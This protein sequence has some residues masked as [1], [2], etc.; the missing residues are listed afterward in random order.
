MDI[1]G[2]VAIVFGGASGLGAATAQRLGE[3]GARVAVADRDLARATEVAQ[4]I[5][6]LPIGVD[7]SDERSAEEAIEAVGG[8]GAL[9]ICVN[10]AGVGTPGKLVRKGAPAP[11][12]SFGDV[13]AVNLL[14]TI[15]VLR[16]AASAMQANELDAG[17]ERGVC[18][19]TASIAAFDGQIGQIAYAASKAGVAGVTLPAAR[20]LAGSAI[21]VVT[22]APGIFD[23]P[24][25]AGL[26]AA[27]RQS[28]EGTV[29]F[30]SRL[31]SPSEYA[32]LVAHIVANQMLNGEVIRLD[33]ALRMAAQ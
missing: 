13:L 29:P 4:R 24:M 1:E 17:G 10:C 12:R 23:T 27:A 28:L 3:G 9:R 2:A 11:L 18:V 16:C 22:I 5:D 33:G 20:E 25:L 30:P 6:G 15:N 14:G 31:G 32:D 8:L 7:V 19:N 26:P 21:R